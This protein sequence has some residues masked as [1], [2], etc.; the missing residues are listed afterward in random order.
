MNE[1]KYAP[2]LLGAAFLVVVVTSLAGG[3]LLA[4]V[5]GG[6]FGS[7]VQLSGT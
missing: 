1:D 2:R 4:S 7:S 5:T 3:L 6:V